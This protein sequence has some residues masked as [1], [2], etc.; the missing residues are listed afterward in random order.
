MERRILG[1]ALPEPPQTTALTPLP[2]AKPLLHKPL[3]TPPTAHP[4]V[5]IPTLPSNRPLPSTPSTSTTVYNSPTTIPVPRT[6]EFHHRKRQLQQEESSEAGGSKR[7]YKRKASFN[8]CKHC[9]LPKTK[10][11]GHSRHIGIHS[12]DTFC[13]AV[14][15]K[16]F[17]NKEAWMAARKVVNPPKPK[18]TGQK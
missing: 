17:G 10:D 1:Q 9:K 16:E 18:S 5:T 7:N 13:P 12:V 14:E 3:P 6:T 11:F 8:T 15:G 2:P 4:F